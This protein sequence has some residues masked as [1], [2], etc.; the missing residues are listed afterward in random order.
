MEGIQ[1]KNNELTLNRIS[2]KNIK[3]S[4]SKSVYMSLVI[5]L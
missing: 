5:V 1:V 4:K 3:Y 2:N